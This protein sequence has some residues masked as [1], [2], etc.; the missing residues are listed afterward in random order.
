MA[1][2]ISFRGIQY[3]EGQFKTL[4]EK[5]LLFNLLDRGVVSLEL[6]KEELT[7]KGK[8]GYDDSRFKAMFPDYGGD[9]EVSLQKIF[10]LSV[11]QSKAV[12]DIFRANSKAWVDR[13]PGK[14]TYD[15]YKSFV[16]AKAENNAPTKEQILFQGLDKDF[17]FIDDMQFEDNSNRDS[18]T[19]YNK[20]EEVGQ[21]EISTNENGEKYLSWIQRYGGEKGDG[22]QIY[23]QV[24]QNLIN[25]GEKVTLD[26]KMTK[27]GFQLR[28]KLAEEGFLTKVG[29]EKTIENQTPQDAIQYETPPFIISDS[30]KP[31]NNKLLF[32]DSGKLN[33]KNETKDI[34]DDIT[35]KKIGEKKYQSFNIEFE[36]GGRAFGKIEDGIVKLNG[37]EAGRTGDGLERK[38][39]TKVY[40]RVIQKLSNNGF[41]TLTVNT[42][43]LASQK[44]LNNLVEKGILQ[45]PRGIIGSS[46][47][48]HPTTFT[49]TKKLLYQSTNKPTEVINKVMNG[50]GLVPQPKAF[51][52]AFSTKD[53][54]ASPTLATQINNFISNKL[55]IDNV[56]FV[57]DA[58][59]GTVNALW[60]QPKQN[61]LFQG[62][63]EITRQP[64][65]YWEEPNFKKRNPNFNAELYV[66]TVNKFGEVGKELSKEYTPYINLVDDNGQ[67][68]LFQQAQ[69]AI[70]LGDKLKGMS[71]IIYAMI[72]PNVS[73]PVHE[74]AHKWFKELNTEEYAKTENFVFERS[75]FKSLEEFKNSEN[76]YTVMQETFARGF[77]KYLAT[78]EAPSGMEVIFKQFKEW[79]TNIYKGIVGSDIDIE[80]NDEMRS[81]YAAMLGANFEEKIVNEV[82]SEQNQIVVEQPQ[83]VLTSFENKEIV[84]DLR[85]G[86]VTVED[87]KEEAKQSDIDEEEVD[88][89]EFNARN[90]Q[91]EVTIDALI[92][93]ELGDD[94][95]QVAEFMLDNSM[96]KE[97]IENKTI[98]PKQAVELLNKISVESK[99]KT[100]LL[101]KANTLLDKETKQAE[102]VAEKQRKLEE[103]ENKKALST[104]DK[105]KVK[106][107][108]TSMLDSKP[109]KTAFIN[110][111]KSEGSHLVDSLLKKSGD[112]N[113]GTLYEKIEDSLDNPT[114]KEV[115][116]DAYDYIYFKFIKTLDLE[117]IDKTYEK[118]VE[119]TTLEK[120]L[121]KLYDQEKNK[122]ESE[123]LFKS[124]ELV[125]P[126]TEDEKEVIQQTERETEL[127][128]ENRLKEERR[129]EILDALNEDEGMMKSREVDNVFYSSVQK[130][131]KNRIGQLK[132]VLE[133]PKL[134]FE[135]R[136]GIERELNKYLNLSKE[137]TLELEK[138]RTALINIS[139][140][141]AKLF[142]QLT[143]KI[144]M[145]GT[146]WKGLAQGTEVFINYEN[147][148]IDTPIHELM[149]PFIV[150]LKISNKEL[151]NNLGNEVLGKI[152]Y[153]D[154]ITDSDY[155]SL[156][157][158]EQ[159][160]EAMARYIGNR[161][162]TVFN[163]NGTINEDIYDDMQ[164]SFIFKFGKWFKDVM[165]RILSRFMDLVRSENP[166]PG[167]D[168]EMRELKRQIKEMSTLE[169][170]NNSKFKSGELSKD[171]VKTIISSDKISD[172]DK[173]VALEALNS[174]EE[175]TFLAKVF[176]DSVKEINKANVKILSNKVNKL[177]LT[178][179][180]YVGKAEQDAEKIAEKYNFKIGK[181]DTIDINGNKA[182]ERVFNG[183]MSS[184]YDIT[185]GDLPITM[186]LND[187]S[188]L[189]IAQKQLRF[190][191]TAEMSAL[192]TLRAYQYNSK[193]SADNYLK[194]INKR[195]DQLADTHRRV[196]ESATATQQA[197]TIKKILRDKEG[198]EAVSEYVRFAIGGIEKAASIVRQIREEFDKAKAGFTKVYDR[199]PD[200]K[201]YGKF[202]YQESSK[203]SVL[204]DEIINR[205]QRQLKEAITLMAFYND[206]L[207]IKNFLENT[208]EGKE[209]Q[210]DNYNNQVLVYAATQQRRV[211]NLLQDLST[212]WL[213]PKLQ[214]A[215]RNLPENERLSKEQ[216]KMQLKFSGQ[217]ISSIS[218]WAGA[219]IN[220]RDPLN[221]ILGVEIKDRLNKNHLEQNT[222]QNELRKLFSE[223]LKRT[224][225]KN[226]EKDVQQY[227]KDNYLRK[228]KCWEVI[229]IKEGGEKIY[230]YVER[231][232][233]NTE[234]NQDLF[235]DDYR[236]VKEAYI[237]KNG[238]P[239][240]D[241]QWKSLNDFEFNWKSTNLKNYK[242][243]KFDSLMKDEY[244]K[245][246][247][248]TYT[249]GNENFGYRSLAYGIVPQSFNKKGFW[250]EKLTESKSL[251]EYFTNLKDAKDLSKYD[252]VKKVVGDAG[253]YLFDQDH[254]EK[255]QSMNLD[256]TYYMSVNA[257]FTHLIKPEDVNLSLNESILGFYTSGS[258]YSALKEVQANVENL[259][260]LVNG[261]AFLGITPRKVTK[262]QNKIDPK[263]GKKIPQFTTDKYIKSD[264]KATERLTKQFNSFVDDIFYGKD[265]FESDLK[266]G[267]FN[268][269]L[270]KVGQNLGFVTATMNLAGNLIAGISNIVVGNVQSMGEAVG[271]KYY[272][273]KNWI[274]AQG[275][276]VK[277]IPQLLADTSSPV[278]SK[279]TQLGIIY[280]AIQ[281]EF[282][283]K[284]GKNITGGLA[285]RYFSKDSLFL[286]SH[287]GEH[288]IQLTGFLALMDA[289]KV[290]LNDGTEISLYDAYEKNDK[291][292]YNIR[293]DAKWT[294]SDND[295]F[296]R[297]L[298]GISKDLNG[299]YAKFDKGMV[300]RYWLGN[301]AVQYRKYLYPAWRTRFASKRFDFERETEIE[302]Y[303]RTFG[304][305]FIQDLTQFKFN[306]L[307][308]LANQKPYS[309]EEAYAARKTMF[310]IS[311]MIGCM[312]LAAALQNMEAPD[313]DDAKK[314][315]ARLLLL[316]TR[317]NSDISQFSWTA[318]AEGTKIITNP[319]ASFQTTNKILK[320]SQQIFNDVTSGGFEE[321]KQSG[322]G[323]EEGDTK[324]GHQLEAIVPLWKQ[325]KRWEAPE[326]QLAYYNLI[327][328]D[329]QK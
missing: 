169:F 218:Y 33:I 317:L 116:K 232:A 289:T 125:V 249:E 204:T 136:D 247:Y 37:I 41:T 83:Q 240:T 42:Q 145:F 212:E 108:L 265:G 165:N 202:T 74:L 251:K 308:F 72:D 178:Q 177:T 217:D 139:E 238:E 17:T 141:L 313:D 31:N 326:D 123:S 85:N 75:G 89:A 111:L 43:S 97:A 161:L 8:E 226:T 184:T 110:F 203:S 267:N 208:E 23:K 103:K 176:V 257:P 1:C 69:A 52:G 260:L 209:F 137:E 114:K 5:G 213:Y 288:Q 44:V 120:S 148:T 206:V 84:E 253:S 315:R 215:Q 61:L 64:I 243:S 183:D 20:D 229:D 38:K 102:K 281:G 96:L 12:A 106:E 194:K 50:F 286:I 263:T 223:F 220:Q 314:A 305:K 273:P 259:R 186:N 115:E 170:L 175:D 294:D 35:D 132:K 130:D 231:D 126:I 188:N 160:D 197:N 295:K 107:I 6:N 82:V 13:N 14:T 192:S 158:D 322:H 245:F 166:N 264:E 304:K 324:L 156:N 301:L 211:N 316:T 78:E 30:V 321:Y 168:V 26:T 307:K 154:V 250:S 179:R 70:W 95:Q 266:I 4:L 131:V 171:E 159:I 153:T 230:G 325:Y 2:T 28:E 92:S 56:K 167:V 47:N 268:V 62:T 319:A 233:F 140:R 290:K 205:Q 129:Q 262:F 67:F 278:K 190:D 10:G 118:I 310:D 216:F 128:K 36:D 66:N 172:Y 19:V 282:R 15:Y 86:V 201:N 18:Y 300:Q 274:K 122:Q 252:K 16:F 68:L 191:Y 34:L 270:N 80:L 93:M 100:A 280:D 261:N 180:N 303:Y 327:N 99:E 98:S 239:R 187:V 104:D 210:K 157:P 127:E 277:N 87:V 27:G 51:T 138:N 162:S 79:L 185:V 94:F 105:F 40:E 298:H 306:T 121:L 134:S 291:G 149:H 320:I 76:Y 59:Y 3:T 48:E 237:K 22:L 279:I 164:D 144:S 181:N 275:L 293:T 152:E 297:T 58:T 269:N 45:D 117:N 200:S 309:K 224:G 7:S 248:D 109:I 235:D 198:V 255:E 88:N 24:I 227:Y 195:L 65:K 228:A 90:P 221:A 312:V 225:I 296:T 328:K 91:F 101:K 73:S 143:V 150:A 236:K 53:G 146:N 124:Q 174:L 9:I 32:Q 113:Y 241:V 142:P 81:V 287:I 147:A 292:F 11:P 29:E 242:N 258:N 329:L 151:Y 21:I 155:E 276:Y 133:S 323:Y 214:E 199:N 193:E 318:P 54:K 182:Q 49:I 112:I 284:Y 46:G 246:L 135:Q 77:E 302:G 285:N 271:G 244:Y 219:L 256:G 119:G 57:Y 234:Y 63:Q 60:Q 173:E 55:G 283:D 299:N 71:D 254:Y 207:G 39:G 311:I 196:L 25:R 189:L 163:P 222:K 272:S